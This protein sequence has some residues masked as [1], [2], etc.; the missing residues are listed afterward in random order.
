MKLSIFLFL[1]ISLF[2]CDTTAQQVSDSKATPVV[3]GES[4]HYTNVEIEQFAE[5]MKEPNTVILDVRTPQETAQGMIEGAIEIDFLAP[6]FADA[7]KQLDKD[8]T[9]LVYCRSG[10]RSSQACTVM[11]EQGFSKLYNMLGGYNTW[12]AAH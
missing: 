5:L 1:T 8:K 9:Y 11:E 3:K 4:S 2:S 12:S 6:G 7:V 10:N